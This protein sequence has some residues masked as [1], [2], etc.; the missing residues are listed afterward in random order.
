MD[1]IKPQISVENHGFWPKTTDFVVSEF[2]TKKLFVS[3]QSRERI[4]RVSMFFSFFLF[5]WWGWFKSV[6]FIIKRVY[7]RLNWSIYFGKT[8]DL[9]KNC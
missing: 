8:A 4:Q 1:F 2:K 3:F 5:F 9:G 6:D 7:L